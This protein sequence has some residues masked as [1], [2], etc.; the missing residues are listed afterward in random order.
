ETHDDAYLIG[1]LEKMPADLTIYGKAGTAV[2]LAQYG[3]MQKAREALQSINEYSV[4]KEEMGRYFDTRKARYSWC[5]YRIPTQVAAIEAMKRLN[6]D[7]KT[8]E[9]MQRWLLQEK[10]TTS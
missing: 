6:T 3:R 10:R 2:I 1:L 8:I 7:R 5:D 4:Y 9:E